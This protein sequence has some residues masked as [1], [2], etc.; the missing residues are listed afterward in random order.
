M[1]YERDE[2]MRQQEATEAMIRMRQPRLSGRHPDPGS[3]DLAELSTLR[4]Q[5]DDLQKENV[6]FEQ[7][8]RDAEA[9]TE[10][11]KREFEMSDAQYRALRDPMDKEEGDEVLALKATIADLRNENSRLRGV[12]TSTANEAL[13]KIVDHEATIAKLQTELVE[14]EKRITELEVGLTEILFMRPA[15]I[16]RNPLVNQMEEKAKE[17]LT[18]EKESNL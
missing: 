14:R 9:Q 5:N 13:D 2:A 3:D 1:S 11:W 6:R 8:A 7:R 10:K 16:C 15:G 12:S 4:R 18:P 17:L